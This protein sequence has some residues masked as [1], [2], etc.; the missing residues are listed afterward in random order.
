MKLFKVTYQ[1][2]CHPSKGIGWEEHEAYYTCSSLDRLYD[3]I[4]N[5][6]HLTVITIRILDYTPIENTHTEK[7][8]DKTKNNATKKIFSET[9]IKAM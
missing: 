2:M 9:I 3:Y 1:R 4:E 7:L 8:E 6:E 5:E